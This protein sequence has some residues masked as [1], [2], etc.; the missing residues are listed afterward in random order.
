[1]LLVYFFISRHFN[2]KKIY[3]EYRRKKTVQC[4]HLLQVG[5]DEQ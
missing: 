5:T 3:Q 1:M 2:I 4:I